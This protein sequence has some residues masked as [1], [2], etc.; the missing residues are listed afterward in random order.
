MASPLTTS[1]ASLLSPIPPLLARSP[2]MPIWAAHAV[3]FPPLVNEQPT[4]SWSHVLKETP[5][6]AVLFMLPTTVRLD[7]SLTSMNPLLTRL[8]NCAWLPNPPSL[9]LS[10]IYPEL[11]PSPFTWSV[12]PASRSID[13]LL[14][15]LPIVP[16]ES[17]QLNDPELYNVP[18]MFSTSPP[19]V[20]KN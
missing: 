1:S 18:T 11:F 15:T 5:P 14:T 20:V 8:P 16:P 6:A 13:P 3:M 19:E 12:V 10:N 7:V 4:D 17:V 9:K 2:A